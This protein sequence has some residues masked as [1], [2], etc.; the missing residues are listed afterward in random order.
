MTK[1][2]IITCVRSSG[3]TRKYRVKPNRI[4]F[5]ATSNHPM[6]Q[7]FLVA[8]DLDKKAIKRFPL[9]AI[10]EFSSSYPLRMTINGS[11][12]K[13]KPSS[14]AGNTRQRP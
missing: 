10:Q 9:L 4:E 11:K 12:P 2:L 8:L 5:T 3:L 14:K 6:P 13:P 1:E 7:W